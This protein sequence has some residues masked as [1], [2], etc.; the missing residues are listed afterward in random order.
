MDPTVPDN[1]LPTS[2]EKLAI[3]AQ[4][5]NAQFRFALRQYRLARVGNPIRI[6]PHGQ[7]SGGNSPA[8]YREAEFRNGTFFARHKSQEAVKFFTGRAIIAM[9]GLR[10]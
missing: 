7:A 10:R 2:G 8:A 4:T 3:Q 1:C 9:L 5:E 6:E